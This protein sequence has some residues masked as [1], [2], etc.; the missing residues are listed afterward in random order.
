MPTNRKLFVNLAVED[1]DRSIEFFT[2]LGFGFEEGF[3]DATA[4]CMPIGQDAYAMLLVKSRFAGYANKQICDPSTHTETILAISA[5]TREAVDELAEAAMEAGATS[6]GE[7]QDHGFM[8]Y[9]SFHDPDGHHWEV[10]WMDQAV[11]A[12]ALAETA[13]AS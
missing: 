7:T 4:T 6:A 3:T 8:Y 12:E 9:R 5:D 10:V 2:K 11:I 1:L 13:S